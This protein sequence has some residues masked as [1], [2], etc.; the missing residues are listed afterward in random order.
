[1][2]AF[3]VKPCKRQK[4]IDKFAHSLRLGTDIR[5]PFIF[6]YLAF[7]HIC[8]GTYDG[9]RCFQF[10]ACVGNKSFLPFKILFNGLYKPE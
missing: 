3:I 4:F 9:K 6:A 5:K 7:Q 2:T 10:M 1:M 8:I